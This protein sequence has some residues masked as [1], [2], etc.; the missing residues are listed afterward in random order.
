MQL[1]GL[2]N[3]ARRAG[4]CAV[5]SKAQAWNLLTSIET[6]FEQSQKSTE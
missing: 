5:V 4:V 2:E 1:E 6:A 3:A